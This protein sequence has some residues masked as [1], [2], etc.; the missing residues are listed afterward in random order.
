MK[1]LF[2]AMT[3]LFPVAILVVA[4]SWSIHALGNYIYQ[5]TSASFLENGVIVTHS[6]RKLTIQPSQIEYT[7][8][9]V[10]VASKTAVKK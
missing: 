2:P 9:K 5:Q 10:P 6:Q 4:Y 7:V 1:V 8:L 3:Y